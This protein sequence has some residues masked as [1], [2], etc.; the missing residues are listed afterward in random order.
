MD[1]RKKKNERDRVL[2]ENCDNG[3]DGQCG[4][5]GTEYKKRKNRRR[6]EGNKSG[7]KLEIYACMYGEMRREGKSEEIELVGT[8]Q[9]KSCPN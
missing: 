4:M 6:I 2:S 8:Q 7:E 1:R 3:S 5:A 9:S